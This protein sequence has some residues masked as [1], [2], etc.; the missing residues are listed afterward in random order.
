MFSSYH[1]AAW[2]GVVGLALTYGAG[3]LVAMGAFVA[4]EQESFVMFPVLLQDSLRMCT[5]P[6]LG[7]G[8]TAVVGT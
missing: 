2:D 5:L 8:V 4:G 3:F 7:H 6:Q 1:V